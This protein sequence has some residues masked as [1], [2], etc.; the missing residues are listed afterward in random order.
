MYIGSDGEKGY[1]STDGGITWNECTGDPL[2]ATCICYGD[3]E[4]ISCS[5][6]KWVAGGNYEQGYEFYYSDDGI[7]WTGI[8]VSTSLNLASGIQ[9]ITIT[10]GSSAGDGIFIAACGLN[11]LLY[12]LDNGHTWKKC[13]GYFDSTNP[14]ASIIDVTYD[15]P[16]SSMNYNYRLFIATDTDGNHYY[17]RY[18]IGEWI[19]G[20]I[21]REPS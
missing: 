14:D 6:Y 9:V 18:G 16:D 5:S 3:K 20:G 7:N 12:S 4:N 2:A 1:Y 17:D 21:S 11:R 8:N 19:N 15:Y 10:F 13:Y